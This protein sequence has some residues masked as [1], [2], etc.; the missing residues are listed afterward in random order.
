MLSD[1]V[2][3]DE[4]IIL[5]KLELAKSKEMVKVLAALEAT[6]SVLLVADGSDETALRCARNIPRVK[7]L[8]ASLLNALD[9]VNHRKVVMTL[10]A[11]RRVEGLWGGPFVRRK[12]AAAVAGG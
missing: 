4:L 2:R 9:L 5:D 6:P 11:V 3:N 7:M 1:K 10:E 8:P 12:A